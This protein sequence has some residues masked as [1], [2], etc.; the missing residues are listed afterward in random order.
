MFL[1]SQFPFLVLNFQF[2]KTKAFC[3]LDFEA[4]QQA[5]TAY[6]ENPSSTEAMTKLLEVPGVWLFLTTLTVIQTIYFV[7]FH[8]LYS[9][10]PGKKL[11]H[12]HVMTAEG[13]R[14][15]WGSS[16]ARYLCSV[17]T[18]FTLALYGLGYL[19]VCIDPKRRALHDWIAKTF[20]VYDVPASLKNAVKKRA[21]D[22]KDKGDNDAGDNGD[23]EIQ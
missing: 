20:V 10:T 4:M 1:S 6:M 14:L 2:F 22:N 8:A 21:N 19:I 9:A 18:Q 5:F 3:G 12:I 15:T 13:T 11:L 23:K 16:I 7:V 17:L